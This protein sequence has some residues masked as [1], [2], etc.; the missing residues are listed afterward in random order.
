LKLALRLQ[1]ED[2]ERERLQLIK[3]EQNDQRMA[4][5]IILMEESDFSMKAVSSF[6][7]PPVPTTS[8]EEDND[9]YHTSNDRKLALK[10]QKKEKIK[11]IVSQMFKEHARFEQKARQ[12]L[13]RGSILYH[14]DT[15][16]SSVA[17]ANIPPAA[18]LFSI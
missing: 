18:L 3:Q 10:M 6:P 14:G 8:D 1:V 17:V 9:I 2:E 5:K 16:S 15:S 7:Y 13:W 12:K 4:I 11:T